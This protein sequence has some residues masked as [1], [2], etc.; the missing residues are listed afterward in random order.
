MTMR[1]PS[2]A[3]NGRI[4]T[5]QRL[6]ERSAIITSIID[7]GTLF[8]TIDTNV[9]PRPIGH[10][11]ISFASCRSVS[12]FGEIIPMSIR[13]RKSRVIRVVA[14]VSFHPIIIAS[15]IPYLS[16]ISLLILRF[17]YPTTIHTFPFSGFIR[18]VRL[19][20]PERTISK[21]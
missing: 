2:S 18:T 11:S 6:I 8:S 21:G 4:L 7:R 1:P 19:T 12:V 3:G 15:P 5:T 10:E 16:C 14:T 13:P 9:E 20:L 17:L